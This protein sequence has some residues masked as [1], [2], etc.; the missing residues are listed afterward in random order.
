MSTLNINKNMETFFNDIDSGLKAYILG[1]LSNTD[2]NSGSNFLLN[3]LEFTDVEKDHLDTIV[4]LLNMDLKTSNR[5]EGY[6]SLEFETTNP[7]KQAMH[8]ILDGDITNKDIETVQLRHGYIKP[9][10]HQNRNFLLDFIRGI[11]DRYGL[12]HISCRCTLPIRYAVVVS[13]IDNNFV[14]SGETIS[15]S[16]TASIDFL[17]KI[18]MKGTIYKFGVMTNYDIFTKFTNL[19]GITSH[20]IGGMPS[21]TWQRTIENAEPPTKSNTSDTGF[22]L[23]LM[24]KIKVVGNV[25]YFDTGIKVEPSPGYYFELV[26][27]SSISKTGWTLANSVGVID[28]GYRGT[29]IAALLKTRDDTPDLELPVKLVQLIPRP[30]VIM[31]SI[32]SDDDMSKTSRGEGGF[33]STN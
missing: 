7:I 13:L 9:T 26:G 1:Y 28:A 6:N 21:F 33:G 19:W 12:L 31:K 20:F 4:N 23:N 10:F 3:S 24:K 14:V 22:D 17:G 30:L 15:W 29:I 5:E 8:H 11:V 2:V 25:H 27:R 32:C 16:G 18:Y